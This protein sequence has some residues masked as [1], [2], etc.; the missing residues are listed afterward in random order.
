MNHSS[1]VSGL[2]LF[3]YLRAMNNVVK[4]PA[5]IN[6][7]I[8]QYAPGSAEKKALKAA[9]A[10]GRNQVLDIPMYIGGKEVRTNKT[11]SMAP[12]HDHRHVIANY[13]QGDASHVHLPIDAALNAKEAGELRP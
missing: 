12:P 13:H 10:E 2:P 4:I 9:L 3:Q 5:A 1:T 11:K 7:T 8:L 6:E